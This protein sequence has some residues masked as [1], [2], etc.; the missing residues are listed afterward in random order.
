MACFRGE[1]DVK[2]DWFT[3]VATANE[4]LIAPK[5]FRSLCSFDAVNKMDAEAYRYLED[6]NSANIERNRRL[7]IQLMELI[8][9]LNVVDITP[10][11][12]K[13]GAILIRVD[14][15]GD[16]SRMLR[17]LDVFVPEASQ[18]TA[19]RVLHEIGYRI[20]PDSTYSHSSGSY[21]RKDVV[22]SVDLHVAL[23]GP[24]AESLSDCELEHRTPPR[25]LHGR[26]FK[27]PDNELHFLVN[28]YHDLIHDK[29]DEEGLIRLRDILE[30]HD[31]VLDNA[32]PLD[33]SWIE[34]NCNTSRTRRALEI[35]L[36][37]IRRFF[38][39][40]S[41][42]DFDA[43]ATGWLFH[44]RRLLRASSRL[45]RALDRRTVER[46]MPLFMRVEC[47]IDSFRTRRGQLQI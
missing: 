11:I 29:G 12:I 43:T 24:I 47:S 39:D 10:T 21:Y 20:F 30:L 5:L 18:E 32:H 40:S 35:Q 15:P 34:R 27:V 6:L 31:I 17:D 44:Q 45:F 41:L 2:T 25:C 7:H 8:G 1:F 16:C 9:A 28:L 13:G 46:I 36:R 3:V 26:A 14:R 19:D 37:M 23:P 38:N 33:W 42:P 22:G 4:H